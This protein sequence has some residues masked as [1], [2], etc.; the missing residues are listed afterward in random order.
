MQATATTTPATDA[1]RGV[2]VH[3]SG[4]DDVAVYR[5]YDKDGDLLYVGMSKDPIHRWA[6]EHRHRYWWPEVA[7]YEWAW[8]GSRAEARRVERELLSTGLAKY[9]V[10]STPK[11]GPNQ[12]R[13]REAS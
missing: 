8:H 13:Q 12:H 2:I 9:N 10:H 7:S 1:A 4:P 11:H 6:D 5:L 3:P